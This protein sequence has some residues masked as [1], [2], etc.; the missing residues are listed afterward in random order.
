MDLSTLQLNTEI[1]NKYSLVNN[2][3]KLDKIKNAELDKYK[4]EPKDEINIEVGDT[5]QVD[6][7]PQVKLMRWTNEVNFSVRLKDE[8]TI[9][10]ATVSTDK[11]KIVWDKGNIK[12]ESYDFTEDEGGYKFVWYLKEKP[13]TNKIEF[14]I[15]SKG[16]DFFYQPPLTEK[17][18]NGYSE[19]F[20]REIVVN[21]TDVY[22][23]EGNSLVHR[24]DNVVGSYA[25]YHKSKGGMVDANGKDYKT[26][27]AFHI[28]RPHI[29]DAE[30]K[31]TWGILHIENGI[32]SVEI[33]QDFL[34]KAV[35]PIKSNDTIGY[36][37][38]GASGQELASSY[39]LSENYWGISGTGGTTS[40]AGTLDNVK[41]YLKGNSA[42][43][44]NTKGVV[45]K[46]DG[47][48]PDS[49]TR[50]AI[51]SATSHDVT[52]SYSQ[53]TANL[54]SEAVTT[55][56]VYVPIVS[57]SLVSTATG[58]FIYLAYDIA[59]ANP[60]LITSGGGGTKANS[61]AQFYDSPPNPFDITEVSGI[62][63]SIYATYTPSGG[64]LKHNLLT[65]GVS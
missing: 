4:N 52:T 58:N 18:Q 19:E 26:G 61:D 40:G 6:F 12:I 53:F 47:T 29:I 1:T 38:T 57:V 44:T 50:T 41:Y 9:N 64:V 39:D 43:T 34:D 5:K 62:N 20:Q 32:Y 60:N 8:D 31:E 14:T 10:T 28:Y 65:L 48:A 24:P 2:S 23:S 11:D 13:L 36:T 46:I 55:G 17:Y 7:L 59:G 22:D 63:F 37:S 35:Y 33:P 16:L 51:S 42:D 27:K 30:G 49:H 21:E 45:Y 54:G 15:Q 25:V 3:F 56:T